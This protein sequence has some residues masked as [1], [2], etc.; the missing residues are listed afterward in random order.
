[1]PAPISLKPLGK[2]YSTR[3]ARN[4]DITPEE[5]LGVLD[6][7]REAQQVTRQRSGG[8]EDENGRRHYRSHLRIAPSSQAVGRV[9][10]SDGSTE[11]QDMKTREYLFYLSSLRSEIADMCVV[12][13]RMAHER[14]LTAPESMLPVVCHFPQGSYHRVGLCTP[15]TRAR[16]LGCSHTMA[17]IKLAAAINELE[18]AEEEGSGPGSALRHELNFVDNE[19]HLLDHRKGEAEKALARISEEIYRGDGRVPTCDKLR[20]AQHDVQDL[21]R[22]H[23]QYVQRIGEL[24]DTIVTL[25]DRLI[26]EVAGNCR[27]HGGVSDDIDGPR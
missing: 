5:K 11:P 9:D 6:R 8:S 18:S 17:R 19:I 26:E 12:N 4:I 2:L 24:R 10:R 22:L 7:A 14:V 3:M 21:E 23:D 25:M 16:R 1:M 20:T 13:C 15:E 27:A